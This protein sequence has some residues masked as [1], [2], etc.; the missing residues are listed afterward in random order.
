MPTDSEGWS[1]SWTGVLRRERMRR[2]ELAI[3]GTLLDDPTTVVDSVP[4]AAA[5]VGGRSC[6]RCRSADTASPCPVHEE[7]ARLLEP[8]GRVLGE[9]YRLQSLLGSGGI[10]AVYRAVDL[11]HDEPV[12]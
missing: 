7:D 8:I 6:P 2:I 1:L 9:R 5:G 11:A 4:G 12:A 3:Q 10:G